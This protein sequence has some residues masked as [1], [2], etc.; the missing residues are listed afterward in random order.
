M[1]TGYIKICFT[2][3]FYGNCDMRQIIQ[4]NIT[5]MQVISYDIEIKV[6]DLYRSIYLVLFLKKII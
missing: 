1:L 2:K 6:N 4:N 5:T 3:T